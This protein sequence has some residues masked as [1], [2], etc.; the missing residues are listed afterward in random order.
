[1]SKQ[2]ILR[3]FFDTYSQ[4]D[5]SCFLAYLPIPLGNYINNWPGTGPWF[6]SEFKAFSNIDKPSSKYMAC[7]FFSSHKKIEWATSKY[8]E[9]LGGLEFQ[10]YEDLEKS[11]TVT[12][13]ILTGSVDKWNDDEVLYYRYTVASKWAV[14]GNACLLAKGPKYN[15]NDQ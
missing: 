7:S 4:I 10:K 12:T 15:S 8:E 6:S 5:L 2:V 9:V 14:I 13:E 11:H 1:M 3:D